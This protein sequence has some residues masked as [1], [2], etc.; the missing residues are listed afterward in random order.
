MKFV[1]ATCCSCCCDVMQRF[2]APCVPAFCMIVTIISNAHFSHGMQS[3]IF[4]YRC[5]L[6]SQFIFTV[7]T[8][9]KIVWYLI[10]LIFFLQ[11]FRFI[12]FYNGTI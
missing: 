8:D 2:I 7:T 4:L 6:L 12:K 11:Y 3:F 10:N 5:L 9:I 1:G